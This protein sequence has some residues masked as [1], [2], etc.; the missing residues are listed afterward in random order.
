V[1]LGQ[2]IVAIRHFLFLPKKFRP[3]ASPRNPQE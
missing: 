3:G 1:Q 2:D